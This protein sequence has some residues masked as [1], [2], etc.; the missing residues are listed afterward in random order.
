MREEKSVILKLAAYYA[1]EQFA[2]WHLIEDLEHALINDNY[3]MDVYTPMPTRGIDKETRK[4]YQAIPIEKKLDNRV[5]IYRFPLM[6]EKR[7]PIVRALRYII[8]N[9]R[10]YHRAIKTNDVDLVF[11]DSTPP[12]QGMLCAMVAKKLSK[13]YKKKVPFVFNLQDIFPDSLVYTGLSKKNSISWKIGRKIE[14]YTYRHADKIIVISEGFKQN[15]MAK[16]VPEEKIA[17]VPNWVDTQKVQPVQRKD[18]RLIDEFHLD[19][20]KFMV[21]YAGNFGVAQGADIVLRAAEKLQDCKD[22]HFFVLGG[23]SEF[24]KAKEYV[25]EKKLQNVTIDA[26]LPQERVPEV[27]SLGDLALITC[28][29]GA[30]GSGLPSKTWSIMACDTS[31]VASFDTDSELARILETERLGKCVEPENVEALVAAIKE[32]YLQRNMPKNSARSYVEKFASKSKCV[33]EYVKIFNELH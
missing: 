24:Q 3:L 31:I 4:R 19:S 20:N 15:I 30:G 12:T 6:R 5:H 10:Q 11:C 13:K 23:G 28:K 9:I 16:G 22:I 26:L 17:V 21:V 32:V 2:N 33:A 25:A 18:N 8:G 27:Y 7:N 14:D 1:P 29:K